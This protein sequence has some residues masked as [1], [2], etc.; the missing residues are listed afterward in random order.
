ML[1]EVNEVVKDCAAQQTALVVLS[2]GGL[3]APVVAD[4]LES[5]GCDAPVSK[6][7]GA[8]KIADFNNAL[9]ESSGT[10]ANHWTG[11]NTRWLGSPKATEFLNKALELLQSEFDG[12]YLSLLQ[13][14]ATARLLPFW[15]VVFDRAGIVPR[16][17]FVIGDPT[18]AAEDLSERLD[19]EPAAGQLVWLRSALDA[20]MHSRGRRRAFADP[21]RLSDEPA[22]AINSLA[23][24]MQLTFP[25]EVETTFEAQDPRLEKI[26]AL[27]RRES[28]PE[29]LAA[30][31]PRTVEWVSVTYE[32][33]R[34]WAITG[35]AIDARNVLDALREAFDEAAPVF[36]GMGHGSTAKSSKVRE[37][38]QQLESSQAEVLRMRES[39]RNV[40]KAETS[41][42]EAEQA[43]NAARKE[44][45]ARVSHLE[46][47]LAQR[48]AEIDETWQLLAD[49]RSK[50]SSM[51]QEL[52]KSRETARLEIDELQNANAAQSLAVEEA[53]EQLRA[54]YSE[55]VTLTRMLATETSSARKFERM[56]E[57]LGRISQIF[58]RGEAASGIAGWLKQIMPWS[59]QVRRIKRRLEREGLF[60]SGAYL[61]ANPDVRSVGVDPLRHY[62]SHGASEGR[63]LG[64][65]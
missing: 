31:A 29:T 17:V 57:R 43:A 39:V 25:R 48:T 7:N 30:P 49:A 10:A 42:R 14:S 18:R 5:L 28:D 58:E 50:L 11:F 36:L 34:S 12:S 21:A 35:E 9:L 55:I 2:T 65:D 6:R 15:N 51:E 32:I 23:E 54:R 4:L 60:D 52:A 27:L 3:V 26:R 61:N 45:K 63:P 44:L 59:W 62:L 8:S 22:K 33:L 47:A 64:I 24:T 41:A 19:I 38:E 13:D 1:R 37:L 53:Q 20:E 16:Y 40:V 56:A 46:S